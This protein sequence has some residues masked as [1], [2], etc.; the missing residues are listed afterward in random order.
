MGD[1]AGFAQRNTPSEDWST[2]PQVQTQ[3]KEGDSISR[4]SCEQALQRRRERVAQLKPSDYNWMERSPQVQRARAV[5]AQAKCEKCEQEEKKV[6]RSENES[7]TTQPSV[8]EIAA[9][10][11][12]GGARSL[13]HL[14][15]IGKSLG[16]DMSHVQAY[17]GGAAAKAC[18]ALEASAYASG[19][20]IAFKSAPDVGLAAHEAAHVVQQA[21]G[22]VQLSGGM[23]QVG[24]KYENHADRVARE[25]AAGRSAVPLLSEFDGRLKP[26]EPN[27]SGGSSSTQMRSPESLPQFQPQIQSKV[28]LS[29]SVKNI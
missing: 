22:K 26:T 1:G 15:Q 17:V 16:Q 25:T 28:N 11:F 5:L 7:A 18:D 29:S 13:P 10:G 9:S 21:S 4:A 23:G 8:G 2:T 27:V 6:Q 19:N 20:Q 24:D 12:Q 14:N 3:K